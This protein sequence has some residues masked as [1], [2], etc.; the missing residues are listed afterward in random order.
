MSKLA[1]F[2]YTFFAGLLDWLIKRVSIN[3]AIVMTYIAVSLSLLTALYV[4]FRGFILALVLV[5]DNPFLTMGFWL[6]WPGNA[7]ICFSIIITADL[8]V[9]IYRVHKEKLAALHRAL[10]VS[11]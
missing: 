1:L 8:M 4:V 9:F 6:L 5:V 3:T 11:G 2:L 7:E 10:R